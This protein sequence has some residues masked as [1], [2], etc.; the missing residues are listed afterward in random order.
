MDFQNPY[1]KK[2]RDYNDFIN[3]Y[4]QITEKIRL[5]LWNNQLYKI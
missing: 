2:D 1:T 3:T 5:Y 4:Q